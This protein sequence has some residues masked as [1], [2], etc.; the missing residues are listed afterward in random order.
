MVFTALGAQFLPKA[1]SGETHAQTAPILET[2]IADDSGE[3]EDI[4]FIL[5]EDDEPDENYFSA[6]YSYYRMHPTEG[7][8]QVITSCQ[9]LLEVR[10][11]LEKNAP[12][13]GR[14]WGEIHLVAHGNEWSGLSVP[15]LPSDKRTTVPSLT[16]AVESGQFTPLPV[17]LADAKTELHVH[18]CAVGR[19]EK[20][21][22][23]LRQAFAG[24]RAMEVVASPYFVRYD[25]GS[26]AAGGSRH[27][28]EGYYAF[29]P[30]T[31]RPS[32]EK[33][34]RQLEERYPSE[35]IDWQ[36]ALQRTSAAGGGV[37]HHVFHIPLVW[38]V[39]YP[40]EASVPDLA[41]WKA[42]KK[43]LSEQ[44]EL[45]KMLK[46]YDI[47]QEHF[48]WTFLN[49]THTL[50]DGTQV[51]AIRAIGLCSVLTVLREVEC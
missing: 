3:R 33:L 29:F 25:G 10:D 41:K 34:V 30:K 28:L 51:P 21:T 39:A 24:E 26:S 5:G 43:W 36:G 11:F 37:Y 46:E 20:L 44:E 12:A 31:Y 32:D 48:Q 6:A 16:N 17:H 42:Q 4:A 2:A 15:T 9:S 45:K 49:V 14:P 40:D 1:K 13:N 23:A 27:S 47:P 38:V 22:E 8:E 50:E 7:T 18:G 35:N 19:N